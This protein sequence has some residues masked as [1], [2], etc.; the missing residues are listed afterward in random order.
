MQ[1]IFEDRRVSPAC[2]GIVPTI[3]V[4]FDCE[5]CFPR[6]RGDRPQVQCSTRA[7][8]LFPPRARGSSRYRPFGCLTVPVSPA[9]AGIVPHRQYHHWRPWGFPRVRGDRPSKVAVVLD[10][11]VFPP[12]ARGS[13]LIGEVAR[14]KPAV[15]PAC[16]GIVHALR[17]NG[18][19]P[20]GFPRVRGD[21]PVELGGVAL[22]VWFPPRARGS[23][24]LQASTRLSLVVSPACAGIVPRA[25]S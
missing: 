4:G 14:Q 21:R 15:S 1:K 25:R 13:S 8:R 2:A 7:G 16:A 10:K 9:C 20:D 17:L 6:V 11:H 12:R 24:P 18:E 22:A 23:S 5:F 3:D 19:A